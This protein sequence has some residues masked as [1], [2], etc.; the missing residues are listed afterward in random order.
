MRRRHLWHM[1][2][3]MSQRCLVPPPPPP[4]PPPHKRHQA[5]PWDFEAFKKDYLATR[6]GR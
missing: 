1:S 2:S 3:S 4:P 6:R 5:S